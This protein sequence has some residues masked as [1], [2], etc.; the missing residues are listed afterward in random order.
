MRASRLLSI[1]T[2]LQAKGRVTAQALA[3]ACEVSLRT[4]YRDIDALSEAG[5]PVYSERGPEGGYRLLDGYRTRLNGLSREEAEALF[6]TGLPGPAALLGLGGILAGA[7]MKLL[8]ALPADL[9]QSAET[10]RARFHLDTAGWFDELERPALLPELTAATWR[11]AEIL[12]RYRGRKDAVERRVDPLGLVLKNGVWYLIGRV[13]EDLRT[14]RVSRIETLTVLDETFLPPP[15]FDLQTHW[16]ANEAAFE[17]TLYRLH[18][19][20]RLSPVGM[21]RASR[22]TRA[23][24]RSVADSAGPPDADGWREA[25]L[26]IESLREGVGVLS[27]LGGEVEVLGPPELRAAMAEVAGKMARLYAP[28]P[29][30]A[31]IPAPSAASPLAGEGVG[32]ADG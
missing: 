1:L 17:D 9:R 6:L 29:Q 31:P 30:H 22:L 14:Y 19:Q 16:Q 23:R 32:V 24:A 21:E 25:Q 13:G 27:M 5:V 18:A 10:M 20:V 8:A 15:G 4:I 2:T 3:D 26:P 28:L 7:E 12:M 11:Q